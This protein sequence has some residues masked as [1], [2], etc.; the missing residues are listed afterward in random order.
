MGK[1]EQF[2]FDT[3]RREQQNGLSRPDPFSFHRFA[4]RI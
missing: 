4:G 1:A 3:A 2:C